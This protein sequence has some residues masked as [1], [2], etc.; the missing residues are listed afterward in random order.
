MLPYNKQ[1]V[2]SYAS[3]RKLGFQAEICRLLPNVPESDQEF[4]VLD[5]RVK[6][7]SYHLMR[8]QGSLAIHCRSRI[9]EG[10]KVNS[11]PVCTQAESRF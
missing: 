2:L 9:W 8:N 6:G 4:S 5:D 1:A 11:H 3:E 7:M 10:Q